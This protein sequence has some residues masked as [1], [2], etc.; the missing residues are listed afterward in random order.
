MAPLAVDCVA[1]RPLTLMARS[2]RTQKPSVLAKTRVPR[3][4]DGAVVL[5]RIIE[6]KPRLG[7][8]HPLSRRSLAKLLSNAPVEYLFGLERI[9]LRARMGSTV[10]EPFGKYLRD[11]R[12]IILYSLPS[13]WVWPPVTSTSPLIVRMRQFF[14][15]VEIRDNATYVSWPVPEVRMMWFYVEVLAHELG[16]H[17]RHQYRNRRKRAGSREEELIAALH[18]SRFYRDLVRR[19]QRLETRPDVV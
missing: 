8:S 16:H 14:A 12:A 10:G 18:S 4:D 7:D 13:H 3:T 15:E 19:I 1:V 2:Y 17:Y 6:R 9:E 5:P 11:E